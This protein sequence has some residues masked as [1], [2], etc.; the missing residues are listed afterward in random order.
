MNPAKCVFRLPSGKLL[1]FLVSHRGIEGNPDKIKA[2]EMMEAPK[3]INDVQ[4]LNGCITT[5][6]RFISRLG[7]RAQPFFKLLKKSGPVKWHSKA[8]AALQDLKKYLSSPAILVAPMPE[9]LLLLYI[10][11]TNHVVSAALVVEREAKPGTK[12]RVPGKAS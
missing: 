12:A 3:S 5:L 4:R 1:G 10:A 8:E 7:E 6:G 9:E 11:A 2:I